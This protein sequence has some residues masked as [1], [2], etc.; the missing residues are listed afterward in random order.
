MTAAL[1]VVGGIVACIVVLHWLVEALKASAV[2]AE[3]ERQ[4]EALEAIKVRQT[5]EMM[6]ER[7][8]EDVARDLD[9]GRF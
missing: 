8:A 6:R 4:L 7:T 5:R 1:L 9:A 3:R 2:T